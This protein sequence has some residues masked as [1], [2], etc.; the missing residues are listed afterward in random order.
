MR[1][2][3]AAEEHIVVA[4]TNGIGPKELF[5][6]QPLQEAI[7]AFFET[8]PLSQPMDQTNPLSEVGHKRRFSAMGPGG[9][10]REEAG[11]ECRG[12]HPSYYGRLCPVETPEGP[13]VGLITAMGLYA[14]VDEDGFIQEPELWNE[15]VAAALATS[16]GVNDLTEDHWKVVN[17]LRNYYLQ[18]GVAPMIRVLCRETGFS[19]GYI[20]DLFPNG[21]AHGA[22]K[23]AG[24]PRPDNCV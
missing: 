19:L 16:E 8:H 3:R 23:Y 13:N 1:I 12:L 9:T 7:R 4:S 17:Y 24:L 14:K 15:E 18:F 10:T 6:L 2:A 21:P 22:C 5:N 11:P 20:Y